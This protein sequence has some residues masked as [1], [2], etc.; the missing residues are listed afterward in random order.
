[1]SDL[2]GVS[3]YWQKS[4]KAIGATFE[5]MR[6]LTSSAWLC[7]SVSHKMLHRRLR[8]GSIFSAGTVVM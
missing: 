1:M 7:L 8:R 6:L 4:K 3:S 5:L 2:V